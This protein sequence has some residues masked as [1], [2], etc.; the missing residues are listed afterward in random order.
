MM[1]RLIGLIVKS[2]F[3]LCFSKRIVLFLYARNHFK[4]VKKNY[5]Y[6]KLGMCSTNCIIL[7]VILTN[8][9]ASSL[10]SSSPTISKSAFTLLFGFFSGT[11][12]P[13]N[14]LSVSIN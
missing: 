3:Y 8:G 2:A 13:N 14:S 12:R 9:R 7:V 5:I 1:K 6:S 11:T 4:E 10:T